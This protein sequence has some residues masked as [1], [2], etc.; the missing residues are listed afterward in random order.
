MKIG[1]KLD[2]L[3]AT[4][5]VVFLFFFTKSVPKIQN[6]YLKD[7]LITDKV[8]NICD[9]LKSRKVFLKEDPKTS[10]KYVFHLSTKYY[11]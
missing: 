8:W 11:N 7:T 4:K 1:N 10:I 9:H 2:L 5:M 3:M 6:I